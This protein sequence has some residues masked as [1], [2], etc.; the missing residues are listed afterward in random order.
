MILNSIYII[1]NHIVSLEKLEK[2]TLAFDDGYA[3]GD[4]AP[5]LPSLPLHFSVI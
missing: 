4:R 1:I 5:S 2:K 3:A